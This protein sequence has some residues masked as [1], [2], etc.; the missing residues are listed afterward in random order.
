VL[1][2]AYDKLI[3]VNANNGTFLWSYLTISSRALPAIAE[4]M[5]LFSVPEGIVAIG[6]RVLV[7]NNNSGLIVVSVSAVV[8][9]VVIFV[10]ILKYR[11]KR[12]QI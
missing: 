12:I 10:F 4:D 1:V 5:V 8:A 11:K 6:E 2:P 3:C 9:G 7:S